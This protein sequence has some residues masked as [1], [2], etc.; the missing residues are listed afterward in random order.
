MSQPDETPKQALISLLTETPPYGGN[1][2]DLVSAERLRQIAEVWAATGSHFSAGYV[3]SQAAHI[4][5]G[6]M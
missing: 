1:K 6:A 3:F 4:T 5:R 2:P